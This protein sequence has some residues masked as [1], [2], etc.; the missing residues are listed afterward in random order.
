MASLVAIE[1]IDGSGKRT[2]AENLSR[3]LTALGKRV[4]I[5][6]FPRYNETAF[7]GLIA[8]YLDGKGGSPFDVDPYASSLMFAGDRL[9]SMGAITQMLDA[10][11]ILFVDRYVASNAVYNA[12]KAE[13]EHQLRIIEW[14]YRVE[15]D[16]LGIPKPCLNIYLDLDPSRAGALIGQKGPRDYTKKKFDLYEDRRDYL[17][18]CQQ[19]YNGLILSDKVL[20]WSRIAVYAKDGLKRPEVVRDEAIRILER[21]QIL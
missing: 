6:S 11:D 9:E 8:D 18:K 10:L 16:C 3:Y 2:L 4:G 13:E 19:L 21:S 12:A 15:L 17:K 7:S 14:V 1:G 5:L 20:Q